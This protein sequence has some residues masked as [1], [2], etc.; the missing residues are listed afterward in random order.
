MIIIMAMQCYALSVLERM[1]WCA[2]LCIFVPYCLER[3]C[4]HVLLIAK[5]NVSAKICCLAEVTVMDTENTGS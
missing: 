3:L 2:E 1:Q 4:M 5:G